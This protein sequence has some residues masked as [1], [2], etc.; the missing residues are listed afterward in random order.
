MGGERK[1]D[2]R[3][4]TNKRFKIRSSHTMDFQFSRNQIEIEEGQTENIGKRTK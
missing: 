2:A 4:G 3:L 1:T